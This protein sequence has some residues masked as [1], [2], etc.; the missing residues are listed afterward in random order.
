MSKRTILVLLIAIATIL[1]L[2]IAFFLFTISNATPTSAIISLPA[3]NNESVKK[4]PADL[5]DYILLEK[6]A[7]FV[8]LNNKRSKL[9]IGSSPTEFNSFLEKAN[10]KMITIFA[11]EDIHPKLLVDLL[12]LLLIK[13][14]KDYELV[15]I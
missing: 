1:L 7:A 10:G 3:N 9:T 5:K 14:V 6:N 11:K 8:F 13:G 15:R 2:P 12:D 4:S